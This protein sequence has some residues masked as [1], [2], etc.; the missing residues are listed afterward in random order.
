MQWEVLPALPFTLPDAVVAGISGGV[1]GAV[2]TGTVKGAIIGAATAAAFSGVGDLKDVW[3]VDTSTPA[4]LVESAGMHGIV[5]GVSSV[6]SGGKFQ[7]GFLAAAISDGAS[8]MQANTLGQMALGT[9]QTAIVGGIGSVLGGGKFADGAV[10]GAFG[11]LYNDLAHDWARAGSIGGAILGG[12]LIAGGC[13]IV[14]YG[15]CVIATPATMTAGAVGGGFIGG[16][17]GWLAGSSADI[18]MA[19]P[20][21]NAWDPNGPKAPGY[22]GNAE[23]GH[24]DY[25]DPKGGPNWVP[26]PNG[27]GFGWES[28]DGTVWVPSGQGGAAH[29]GP[30]WD[31]QNP[32]G[33]NYDNKYPH[34]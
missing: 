1:G 8:P 10:T 16:S 5:G 26:N 34:Q 27:R 13:D 32:R 15:A 18:L 24:P 33:K 25:S 20:P 6:A 28:G 21:E 31:Q 2:A 3:G 9:A 23:T 29:G 11:Y 22:P 14:S 19:T 12:G 30:H 4:G 17:L 7:A